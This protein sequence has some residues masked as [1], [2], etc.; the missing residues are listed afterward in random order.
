MISLLFALA[1]DAV[2]GEPPSKLHPVVWMGS[3]ITWMKRQN[4]LTTWL[5]FWQGL[6]LFIIGL[7]LV[8]LITGI[9]ILVIQRFP[10]WIKTI[11][12]AVLLKPMFSV[13]SL[14]NA[15]GAV[16]EALEAENLE[17]AR[18]EL[19]WNLVSR[20][21]STL[22]DEEVAAATVSSL[23]ENITDSIVAPLFY[24][25][26]FEPM[27]VGLLVASLY[28]FTN[29]AD[30]MLGYRTKEL[31]YFGKSAAHLDDILNFIPA[32]L[33]SVILFLLLIGARKSAFKGLAAASTAKLSSPNG[34][35][36][37]AMIA[38]G[39]NIRLEK[40][41]VYILNETG[42]PATNKTIQTVQL[43]IIALTLFFALL[44]LGWHYAA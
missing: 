4:R 24:F 20:D 31:E 13:R 6:V 3:Y 36:T 26:L 14:I 21:T 7:V 40:K 17:T 19:S 43:L 44:S 5:A 33:S 42:K 32:R 11:S 12:I 37:M 41:G 30:A 8:I 28:R 27:G 9:G 16:K 29:T 18:Q 25:V 10:F 2:F 15:G 38:G 39:L 1:L 35:W 34:A 23:A 22:N